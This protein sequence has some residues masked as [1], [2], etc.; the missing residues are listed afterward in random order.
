MNTGLPVGSG[1]VGVTTLTFP[2][3][4]E[5]RAVDSLI[6][7]LAALVDTFRSAFARPEVF[8]TFHHLLAG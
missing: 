2:P 5:T 7:S 3:R 4:Q 1:S 6:P 8:V